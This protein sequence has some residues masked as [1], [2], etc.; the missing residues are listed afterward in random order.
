[1]TFINELHG[2][3][4]AL[5][6]CALLFVDEAG[7]PLPFAPNEALLIVAGLLMA[8]GAMP[9]PVFLPL[10]YIC[11]VGGMLAGFSWARALGADRLV[12]VAQR[13]R[14]EKTYL[15]A[16]QR[17]R[18]AR[19]VSIGVTRLIP[20]VRT[21]ATLIAGAARTDL[22][23][24]LKGALPALLVWELVFCAL[25][26]AVGLPAE[27]F[28]S[29]FEKLVASGALLLVAVA[30]AVLAI[31]RLPSVLSEEHELLLRAQPAWERLALAL[32]LDVGVVATLGAGVDRIVRGVLQVRRFDNPSDLAVL[33]SLVVVAYVAATRRGP[34]T[35]AGE[36]IFGV[37]YMSR[38][39]R[40]TRAP[41][42]PSEAE[43]DRAL[44][45]APRGGEPER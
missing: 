33:L 31:R 30:G 12:R 5:L 15:R 9:A 41:G 21:Y 20:G 16:E 14:A 17:L 18:A 44:I 23:T 3:V 37:S 22:R 4:A 32:A 28:L 42:P 8:S 26:A 34:G 36:G 11:L 2:T 24:F 38:R 27:H 29:H 43:A 19:P 25:G 39:H 1:M 40:K 10:A 13:V 45:G 6:L 7:V 35:T